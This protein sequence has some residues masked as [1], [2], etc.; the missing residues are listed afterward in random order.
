MKRIITIA[1]IL[2]AV[3]QPAAS[4]Q[5]LKQ[6]EGSF[7]EPLQKRDSILV[8][9][10]LRYG[11]TL[12]G[13]EDGT[14]MNLQ[15]YSGAFGDTLIVVRNWKVDTLAVRKPKKD[16]NE[17]A[18]YD[19]RADIIISPFEGIAYVKH[20]L[21]FT[22][23]I[24]C[25]QEVLLGNLSAHLIKPET[26]AV[27]EELD[28]GMVLLDV[29]GCI[30]TGLTALVVSRRCQL[31]LHAGIDEHQLVS[32]GIEREILVLQSLAVEADEAALLAEAGGE[33]VHD[34][35]V[36]TAV[37]V[38]R[39]LAYL[40]KFELVY[41]VLVDVLDG[42]CKCALKSRRRRQSGSE[43]NVSRKH[44]V[45][46]GHLAALL[47]G[48]AADSED[49][50]GPGLGRLVLL[51]EAEL[52]LFVIVKGESS[53]PVGPVDFDF[54]YDAAV[55]GSGE[56]ISSVVV[57]VLTDKVDTAGGSVLDTA[58]TEKVFEFLVDSGSHNF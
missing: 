4:G 3:L 36:D 42:K 27:A 35:A 31:V 38:L 22:D 46:S 39:H 48:L 47:D 23:H 12:E 58:F 33:L 30:L 25:T 28:L 7:L 43:G 26:V 17:A 51:I 20:P 53:H 45:E 41:T 13:V 21:D 50:A 16:S 5:S 6:V 34:A 18:R 9:D 49:V 52:H 1:A 14:G 11:F 37:V 57:G 56:D 40:C 19:I 10:Q 2:T 55:D 29:G 15:D 54:R 44:G 24:F 8:A 32:F